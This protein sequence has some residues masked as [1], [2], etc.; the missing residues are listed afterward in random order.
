MNKAVQLLYDEHEIIVN[1]EDIIKQMRSLIGK[2]DERYEDI[3]LTMIDFFRSYAD[4]YHHHKEEEILFPELAKKNELLGDGVVK[5][6]FENH[7]TFREMVSS[8]EENITAKNY[9]GAQ[10][11]LEKYVQMLLDH[12][13]AENDEVFQ[14]A[15]TLLSDAELETIYFKFIDADNELGTDRKANLEEAIRSM[16]SGLI[17]SS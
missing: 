9:A 3:A 4:G 13:G 1:S 6:M 16:R 15:G 11:G 17:L 7:E 10:Q 12:I 14:M 5:E 8:I 2:D